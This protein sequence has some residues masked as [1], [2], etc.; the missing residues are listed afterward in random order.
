MK[1]HIGRCILLVI[2]L[3][4]AEH[5]AA[6]APFSYPGSYSSQLPPHEIIAIV[7]STGLQT[8]GRPERQG[9]NYAVRALNRSGQ[10][11]RVIV[12]ARM[13]RILKVAPLPQDAAAGP[14]DRPPGTVPDGYGPNSRLGGAPT[15]P[16]GPPPDN[17]RDPD[18]DAPLAPAGAARA[19]QTGAGA[20]ARP[21]PKSEQAKSE[22]AKPEQSKTGQVKPEPPKPDQSKPAQSKPAQSPIVASGDDKLRL[23]EPPL[24]PAGGSAAAPAAFEE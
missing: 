15:L 18:A 2:G 16:Y 9:P 17:A 3:G 12:D 23:A 1:Q 22:P 10:E 8:I 4:I 5:A 7:R 14:Y 20:V 11:V 24:S 19:P 13:G 6:Q 21:K